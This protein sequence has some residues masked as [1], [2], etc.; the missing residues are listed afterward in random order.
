MITVE[1]RNDTIFAVERDDGIFVA[2]T[3]ICN[4]LGVSANKQRERIQNDPILSEGGTVTVLPSTGGM[5]ET[6]CL[7]LD[8]INGWLFTID[9]SR[10]K[11]HAVR[12]KVLTYKRECYQVLFRHFFG[13]PSPSIVPEDGDLR[14]SDLNKLKVVHESR[15]IFG[16]PTA[17]QLWF[18]LSLPTVS[19]MYRDPRQPDLFSYTAVKSAPPSDEEGE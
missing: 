12:Q 6:F 1:F 15:M 2:V 10:I 4:A 9:D 19:S 14:E 7:R 8:L 17:A 3:P 13:K 18:K 11:D 5:Q 16:A